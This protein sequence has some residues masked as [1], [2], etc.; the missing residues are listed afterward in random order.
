[1]KVLVATS[2]T[3]GR[4]GNDFCGAV[5]SELVF[6]R[7]PCPLYAGTGSPDC[8]CG[9]GRGFAGLVS[10]QA[11]TTALVLDLP[12]ASRSEYID[13]LG[14]GLEGLGCPGRFAADIADSLIDLV[15]AWP[16]GT[17]VER[18]MDDF[19][20]RGVA[21]LAG[22]RAAGA[23]QA[24][25]AAGC[26]TQWSVRTVQRGRQERPI[27]VGTRPRGPRPRGHRREAPVGPEG[28]AVTRF[29]AA[30]DDGPDDGPD[31]LYPKPLDEIRFV[32]PIAVRQDRPGGLAALP[33]RLQRRVGDL[34]AF[35]KA[36]CGRVAGRLTR[37]AGGA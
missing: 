34:S 13:A 35:G 4:R 27:L 3:Q 20:P 18:R 25:L 6:I 22:P 28:L 7:P 29:V 26:S 37:R 14:T 36:T 1:M 12:D 30:P 32:N 17:I 21:L 24:G 33:G 23:G 31:S 9:C 11:S 16:V 19:M 15:A 5:E 10:G 2:L 8:P